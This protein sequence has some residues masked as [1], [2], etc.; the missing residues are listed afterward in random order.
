MILGLGAGLPAENGLFNPALLF[1]NGEQGFWFDPSDLST[2]YQDSAGT[3]AAAAGQ[4]VGLILDKSKGLA[5]GPNAVTAGIP[6]LVSNATSNGWTISNGASDSYDSSTNT[7]ATAASSHLLRYDPGVL[8]AGWYEFSFSAK[9]GTIATPKLSVVNLT[10]LSDLVAPQSYAALINPSGY[11]TVKCRFYNPSGGRPGIYLVRDSGTAGT[12][13]LDKSATRLQTLAGNHA[14]QSTAANKP[15]LRPGA[16]GY[17][18]EFDGTDDWLA[19]GVIDFSASDKMTVWAGLRK[20]GASAYGL[21]VES[22]TAASGGP[23]RF[24]IFAPGASPH[25]NYEIGLQG[26][27]S[28]TGYSYAAYSAP[29]TNVLSAQ[30]DIGGA[31]LSDELKVRINGAAVTGSD[32]GTGLAAGSGNFASDQPLYIGRRA[33]TLIPFNGHIYGLIV[34]GGPSTSVQIQAVE[35][36]LNTKTRAY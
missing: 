9:L 36:W 10:N 33:G 4:A 17:Y 30:Y 27:N 24:G 35:T 5:L 2:V 6:T 26:T 32:A 11:T 29:L 21:L 3:T 19:T 7:F 15:I 23:G 1:A 25:N 14:T 8:A 12:M 28:Y 31:L 34:R 20:I 18:L 22:G 16:G 13:F